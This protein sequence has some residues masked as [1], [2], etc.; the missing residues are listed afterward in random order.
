ME[1]I[2][3]YLSLEEYCLDNKLQYSLLHKNVLCYE[4]WLNGPILFHRFSKKRVYVTSKKLDEFLVWYKNSD[5]EKVNAAYRRTLIK[6]CK[7]KLDALDIIIP[8][9]WN[10]DNWLDEQSISELKKELKNLIA[11]SKQDESTPGGLS[12]SFDDKP[13]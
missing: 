11:K 12:V 8:E 13:K 5:A 1:E 9:C 6:R 4:D 2:T 3:E 7:T 10:D